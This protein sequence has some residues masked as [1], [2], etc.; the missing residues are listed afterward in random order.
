MG[1]N[2]LDFSSSSPLSLQDALGK[3]YNGLLAL[4]GREFLPESLM[5]IKRKAADEEMD[6]HAVKRG[7]TASQTEEHQF[8]AKEEFA[9][10]PATKLMW[11]IS[12][13]GSLNGA[14]SKF[15]QEVGRTV[16]LLYTEPGDV[17]VDPFA[18]HNSRMDLCI[19]AG[20]NYVGCDLSGPFMEFNNK[21]A[22]K[23]RKMYP[24]Q[25]IALH[26]CDSRKQPI[27]DGIGDFTITSP[28]YY[29]IEYYGD[30]E[31]QL[32]KSK[33]YDD[34]ME[35]MEQV[36]RENFR[37]LKPGA[38]SAWF[39][40]DFRRNGVFH[41]YHCDIIDRGRRVGFTPHDIMV[42]DLGRCVRDCFINQAVELKI[43]PKRH[44]YAV[45]LKKP[46]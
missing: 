38:Y 18:G 30:E 46:G 36:L 35:G 31:E 41:L 42:V 5:E 44:E 17:V 28:P 43:L 39:I 3:G 20:R 4:F 8:R 37:T 12:G 15:P 45:I 22:A 14:L 29:D 11:H 26:H 23:L 13:R 1:E 40:N 32:G 21:R 34:F 33:T 24:E 9:R 6:E 25:W 2:L 16:L 27:R 7:Y 19:K 10:D